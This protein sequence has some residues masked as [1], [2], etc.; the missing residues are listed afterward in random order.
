MTMPQWFALFAFLPGIAGISLG[1][2]R[3]GS[4]E[5]HWPFLCGKL[6]AA[7]LRQNQ[8]GSEINRLHLQNQQAEVTLA[9]LFRLKRGALRL[10]RTSGAVAFREAL[11]ERAGKS[12]VELRALGELRTVEVT[13]NVILYEVNVT[14]GCTPESLSEFL[15]ANEEPAACPVF[16]W[17]SFT[18]KP[19]KSDAGDRL[20]LTGIVNGLHWV[21]PE[22]AK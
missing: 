22:E 5:G 8:L 1:A 12:G 4:S 11:S 14:M 18:L 19:E 16:R 10:P 7:G 9:E 13:E 3:L 21:V 20:L 6:V 15:A 17:K 2:W